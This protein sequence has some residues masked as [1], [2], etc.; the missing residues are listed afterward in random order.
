MK[1]ALFAIA[2]VLLSC[3]TPVVRH[4]TPDISIYQQSERDVTYY[5][6]PVD[7]QKEMP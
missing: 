5:A 4:A 7:G 2:V 6:P 1:R 3:M